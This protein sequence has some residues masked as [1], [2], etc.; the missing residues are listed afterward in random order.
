ML[1]VPDDPTVA[2]SALKHGVS[3]EDILH[4]YRNPI[5][6]HDIDEGLTMLIGPASVESETL[7]CPMRTMPTRMKRV[8]S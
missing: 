7:H 3:A 5:R 8:T 1:G 6:A 4:V 2:A